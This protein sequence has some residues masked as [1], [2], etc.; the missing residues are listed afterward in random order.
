MEISVVTGL[1]GGAPLGDEPSP[2]LPPQL[3]TKNRA[4]KKPITA[5]QRQIAMGFILPSP[6]RLVEPQGSLLPPPP[7]IASPA[8]S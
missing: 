1:L 6:L 4:R 5:F 8:V 3:G 2:P 7:L